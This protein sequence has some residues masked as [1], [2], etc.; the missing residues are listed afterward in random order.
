MTK[1][2]FTSGGTIVLTCIALLGIAMTLWLLSRRKFTMAHAIVWIGAFLGLA[3]LVLVPSLLALTG[4]V[5][6]TTGPDGS[7]RLMAMTVITGFLL[8]LSVR[9]SV[10]THRFEDLVQRAGQMEFELRERIEARPQA[11]GAPTAS[12][13][14]VER[15]AP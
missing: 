9:V 13:A 10:L 14:H 3:V 5:L 1:N 15:C 2:P 7:L 12:P 11:Q 8:F 6:S 4:R